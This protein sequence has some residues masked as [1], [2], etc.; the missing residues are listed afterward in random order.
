MNTILLHPLAHD[1]AT[2]QEAQKP[3][4]VFAYDLGLESL[5]YCVREDNPD[6][7]DPTAVGVRLVPSTHASLTER[8]LP[9]RRRQIRTRLAHKARETYFRH[10]WEAVY[11]L[12]SL[13]VGDKRWQ[14]QTTKKS[15][16][17][18]SVGLRV[19]ILE[20]IA[21]PDGTPLEDWQYFKAFH[22]AIQ[23]RGYEAVPW[24]KKAVKGSSDKEK[25]SEEDKDEM[26]LVGN[27]TKKIEA[28]PLCQGM[29]EHYKKPCYFEAVIAGLWHW[30][31]PN[32]LRSRIPSHAD[33]VRIERCSAPRQP[34]VQELTA[35][36]ECLQKARPHIEGLHKPAALEQFLYG[37]SGE[38]C[39]SYHAMQKNAI[40]ALKPYAKFRGSNRAY[41]VKDASEKALPLFQGQ[42]FPFEWE[43]VLSQ[44]V[45]RFDN[46][47][48]A[49]C[50]LIRRLNVARA[51]KDDDAYKPAGVKW[52]VV[53]DAKALMLLKNLRFTDRNYTSRG[54]TSGELFAVWDA[55]V[56]DKQ[57]TLSAVWLN[58]HLPELANA[59]SYKN[60]QAK[61][62]YAQFENWKPS[63]D[64]RSSLSRPAAYLLKELILSGQSP[65]IFIQTFL[66]AGHYP[67]PCKRTGEILYREFSDDGRTGLMRADLI[68][69]AK[70][71]GWDTPWESLSL[72]DRRDEFLNE[73]LSVREKQIHKLIATCRNNLVRNRLQLFFN[74]FKT[75]VKAY[76]TPSYVVLEFAR[77]DNAL[78]GNH[79]KKEIEKRQKEHAVINKRHEEYLVTHGIPVMGKNIRTLALWEEQGKI[80]LYTGKTIDNPFDSQWE[81]EHV[82]PSSIAGTSKRENL[83]LACSI[84]NKEKGK[85]TPYEW[86]KQKGEQPWQQY[87]G[88]IETIKT[89]S[90]K[91]KSLLSSENARELIDSYNGL[92]DTSYLSRLVQQVVHLYCNKGVG[93]ADQD[94]FVYVAHGT[95]TNLIA[96]RLNAY[97]YLYD[98]TDKIEWEVLATYPNGEVKYQYA[99][100]NRANKRHHGVDAYML[101]FFRHFFGSEKCEETGAMI[102]VFKPGYITNTLRD[103]LEPT[104]RRIVPIN[105]KRN[106]IDLDPKDTVYGIRD[107]KYVDK[108]G[109]ERD[110]YHL[111]GRSRITQKDIDSMRDKA[112]AE[113]LKGL[114]KEAWKTV[115]EMGSTSVV[116]HEDQTVFH[117]RFKTPVRQASKATYNLKNEPYK[118]TELSRT[119]NGRYQ[120][121]NYGD[122]TDVMA[123]EAL[124][125]RERERRNKGKK[126]RGLQGLAFKCSKSAI[127]QVLYKEGKTWKVQ[128]L[129]THI[130][131]QVLLE[132]LKAKYE[133]YCDAE[134]QPMVFNTGCYIQVQ[135]SHPKLEDK[136]IYPHVPYELSSLKSSGQ[137]DLKMLDYKPAVSGLIEAGLS[138]YTPDNAKVM[139]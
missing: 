87:Q 12:G 61:K 102:T 107:E 55:F 93:A 70:G 68:D 81:I 6:K 18:N 41:K 132:N 14:W 106:K 25:E 58:K 129:Y 44:K 113:A 92:A 47:I 104:T 66:E 71:M 49:K 11:G 131:R 48:I 101:S 76:G 28:H 3:K 15:K 65:E 138:L 5:G 37:R 19:A 84:A 51:K 100:K 27:Y 10:M 86:L 126:E 57:D 74:F 32:T 136:G 105:I 77:S 122:V 96:K 38:F 109:Q 97:Q 21:N 22:H 114:P 16:L 59:V 2:L 23:R 118:D 35:L 89:L 137:L 33:K 34:V 80:C 135:R 72:G 90:K 73:P 31:N 115:K 121:V 110:A 116:L 43:G 54:L 42:A 103:A 67:T 130:N 64:G 112:L 13:P 45:A 30:E 69:F 123:K 120:I 124:A 63:S 133:L 111:I 117:P 94:R 7:V 75:Q 26:E 62:Q 78:N 39:A 79:K 40:S 20:G 24:Q 50:A 91:K 29:P 119:E 99:K 9:G 88:R 85:R 52:S 4:Y 125:T 46:R 8:G 127:G 17:C 108:K 60:D 128:P 83:V 53:N 98:A 82:V 36:F 56:N 139:V 95:H 1:V 134:G